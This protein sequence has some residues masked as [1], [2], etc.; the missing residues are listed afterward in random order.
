MLQFALPLLLAVSGQD[1]EY[2]SRSYDLSGLLFGQRLNA[3]FPIGASHAME[4]GSAHRQTVSQEIEATSLELWMEI[5]DELIE[6]DDTS[7]FDW[8]PVMLGVPEVRFRATAAAHEQMTALLAG[9]DRTITAQWRIE[10]DCIDL[11]RFAEPLQASGL[12]P[13]ETA[14]AWVEGARAARALL[15]HW[16]AT[17]SPG[18]SAWLAN[19]DEIPLVVSFGTEIASSAWQLE[20]NLGWAR[21]GSHFMAQVAPLAGGHRLQMG[22]EH[23]LPAGPARVREALYDGTIVIGEST[24]AQETVSAEVQDQPMQTLGFLLNLDLPQGQAALVR[25]AWN[26]KDSLLGA[27]QRLYVVRVAGGTE[28]GIQRIPIGDRLLVL[29]AP[30]SFHEARWPAL[31]SD[32]DGRL[33][34]GVSPRDE[35]RLGLVEFVA[36]DPADLLERLPEG[37]RKIYASGWVIGIGSTHEIGAGESQ[38]LAQLNPQE[39]TP[40]GQLRVS[41]SPLEGHDVQLTL[42]VGDGRG[43]LAYLLGTEF[44]HFDSDAEVATGASISYW[45]VAAHSRGLAMQVEAH[46][47]AGGRSR[48]MGYL[49]GAWALSGGQTASQLT[50]GKVDQIPLRRFCWN[51]AEAPAGAADELTFGAALPSQAAG[52]LQI[53]F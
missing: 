15:G 49:N 1:S 40:S 17:S 50:F 25:T 44:V 3:V 24:R 8:T 53:R 42:P 9:I 26:T 28:G 20:A 10:V 35:S 16:S 32:Y 19:E 2:S 46:R 52:T 39:I 37:F 11:T 30:G 14:A 18:R 27:A 36:P 29:A 31:E 41:L 4:G 7:Q 45:R 34:L 6:D 51:F 38:D 12:V 47:D 21:S 22:L 23:R 48:A 13:T 5:F 33:E 43:A